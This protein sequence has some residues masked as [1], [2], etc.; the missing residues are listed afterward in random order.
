MHSVGYNSG[1]R[2]IDMDSIVFEDISFKANGRTILS[3]ISGRIQKGEKFALVGDNGSGKSTL[4]EI[5]LGDLMPDTGC[6]YFDVEDH[7]SIHNTSFGVVYDHMPLFPLLKVSELVKFI[8]AMHDVDLGSEAS[9]L[10]SLFDLDK[11][12]D[13]QIKVLSAGERQRVAL[14]LS[15]V[16]KPELLVLDEAFSNID[17]VFFDKIWNYIATKDRTIIFTSHNWNAL[18]LHASRI[19]FLHEGEQLGDTL[20]PEEHLRKV[21]VERKIVFP[22]TNTLIEE[23]QKSSL[24]WYPLEDKVYIFATENLSALT[25]SGGELYSFEPVDLKDIYILYKSKKI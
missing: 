16:H 2:K 17:P 12:A 20:S 24:T 14:L 22:Y 10:I 13:R 23:L 11:I 18:R 19:L 15:I 25:A 1:K 7:R 9:T 3:R 5:L 21:G 8:S 4:L 6:L